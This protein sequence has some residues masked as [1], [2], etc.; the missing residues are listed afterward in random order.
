MRRGRWESMTPLINDLNSKST[1]DR[2]GQSLFNGEM[3]SGWLRLRVR[4][5]TESL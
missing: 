3:S 4:D 2:Q 1:T 5:K